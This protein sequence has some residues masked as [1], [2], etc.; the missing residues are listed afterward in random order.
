[1]GNKLIINS[2]NM[3]IETLYSPN[4]SIG[5]IAYLIREAVARITPSLL[6]D[7][8]THLQSVS[9]YSK[10]ATANM[11]IEH[12]NAVV[13]NLTLF[14]TSEIS[15]GNGFFAGGSPETMRPK[16]ERGHGQFRFL[17]ISP[18]QKDDGVELVLGTLPEE[19]KMKTDEEFMKYAKL[20]DCQ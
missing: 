3:S 13:S 18:I 15:F 14:Q 16:I 2:P 12:M 17:V 10:P 19:L 5:R 6:H 9:D 7:V 8:F 11:G 4:T 20:V 1:M